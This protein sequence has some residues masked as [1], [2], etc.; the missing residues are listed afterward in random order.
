[1]PYFLSSGL[2]GSYQRLEN[3]GESITSAGQGIGRASIASQTGDGTNTAVLNHS[4]DS[5]IQAV[6]DKQ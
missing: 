5:K 1:V 6:T 2:G 4:E 3:R